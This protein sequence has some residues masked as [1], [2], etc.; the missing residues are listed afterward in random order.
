MALLF[1]SLKLGSLEISNKIVIAP[2]CQYSATEEAEPTFWHAQQWA[3]YALSGAGMCI[4]E[5]TAVSPEGRISDAD[6]GLWNNR[7]RDKIQQLLQQVRA[8]STMPFAI[9]L[10]HA[11]RKASVEKPWLTQIQLSSRQERGWQ[12]VSASNLPFRT[13]DQPP[14]ALEAMEIEDIID[15]FVH[16]GLRAIQAGFS[17][18]E[19]HAAHGYL[20]HQFLSPLSNQRAD[21]YG[22]SLD[23]RMRLCLEIFSAMKQHLPKNFPIGV[24]LSAQDWVEGGWDLASSIVLAKQLQQLGTAYIHV[25][26]GGLDQQQQVEVGKNYQVPFAEK[27]KQHVDIPVIAVG[28]ITDADQAEHILQQQQADAIAIAR[29]ILYDPRWPWHAAARLN[30][31]VDA[32]PQ[33][34]R[35]QPHEYS[36]LFKHLPS[37]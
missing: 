31:Q 30:H 32:A 23:N 16:A 27:I 10:S 17:A 2:M 6:L 35:C 26:S 9:Q 5:A 4:V 11:G 28:L 33:Y 20:I 13:T 19:I 15:D 12:T 7:Q 18:I 25:S 36:G 1:E 29:A 24:R 3:S 22:G 37:R 34:L 21:Q 14:I 8:Y